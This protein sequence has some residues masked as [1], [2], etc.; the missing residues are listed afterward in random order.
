MQ[1]LKVW[2]TPQQMKVS[3]WAPAA[4][5]VGVAEAVVLEITIAESLEVVEVE[6]ALEITAEDMSSSLESQ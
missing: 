1:P 4:A 2:E 6:A 5:E 3:I